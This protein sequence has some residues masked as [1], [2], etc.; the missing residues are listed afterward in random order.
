MK[1]LIINDHKT[2]GGA[3]SV[4]AMQYQLLK[5]IISVDILYGDELCPN[6][7]VFSYIYSYKVKKAVANKLEAEN[8]DIVHLHNF[9]HILSPSV[10]KALKQAKKNNN[11][12]KV[13]YTAHDYHLVCPNS[14]YYYLENNN[15]VN[16]LTDDKW[17]RM[18]IKKIDKRSIIHNLL[19]KA[20][21]FNAYVL[22]DYRNVIDVIT[23]PSFFLKKV[24]LEHFKADVR[25]IRNPSVQVNNDDTVF[26]KRT[27][28]KLEIVFFGRLS[29][30]KGLK[31]FIKLLSQIDDIS[32]NFSIIG[33]G[34][35]YQEL[36]NLVQQC[37]IN[38]KVNF[39]GKMDRAELLLS[40][41]NYDLFVL[42]SVWYENA[43]MSILE[44][45][46]A[47]LMIATPDHGGMT[48]MIEA[49]GSG[50]HFNYANPETLKKCFLD[51]QKMKR[52]GRH[53]YNN[54]L[55]DFLPETFSKNMISLYKSVS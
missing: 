25:M 52:E 35:Q 30:E 14:G 13:I 15:I 42:P 10:L 32:Y 51:A 6:I 9:Y 17:P 21:W 1:V 4:V 39:I 38:D 23:T 43:P 3:E 11:K 53:Q 27:G 2:G 19:K 33:D 18:F 28:N 31:E 45:A 54:N 50:Y 29:V 47:N 24:I 12:L 55:D 5:K 16:F 46:Q 36:T 8:Y 7:N 48:E 37:G 26:K 20:Q 41:K 22:H 49:V 40:L 34:P 44:A